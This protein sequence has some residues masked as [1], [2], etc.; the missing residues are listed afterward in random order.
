MDPFCIFWLFGSFVWWRLIQ[1]LAVPPMLPI[2]IMH[3]SLKGFD[4]TA[5]PKLQSSSRSSQFLRVPPLIGIPPPPYLSVINF[6]TIL[7]HPLNLVI[8]IPGLHYN[9]FMSSIDIPKIGFTEAKVA[10]YCWWINHGPHLT[11]KFFQFC[12]KGRIIIWSLLL[13]P[14]QLTFYSLS[15][16]SVSR[17]L[18][19]TFGWSISGLFSLVA[20]L[21]QRPTSLPRSTVYGPGH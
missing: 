9:C 8:P 4:N 19:I 21:K 1:R 2:L 7:S 5:K 11:T 16:G 15:I 17:F 10:V 20:R 14:T 13:N 3:D 6:L 18:S 12:D